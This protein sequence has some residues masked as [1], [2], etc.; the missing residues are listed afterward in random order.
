MT[1][2]AVDAALMGQVRALLARRDA[3]PLP[4]G[5]TRST[6]KLS[7]QADGGGPELLIYDEISYWGVCATDVAAALATVSGDLTV[8]INSPGG[9]V[10]D[11]V[12]IYNLLADYPGQVHVVVDGLAASAA[13]FIA[14]AGDTVTMNRASQMM[15]HDGS[16][17]CWG[18]EADMKA[19]AALLGMVSGTI[20]GIYAARAGGTPEEWRA[21]MLADSGLGT[22][23][24]AEAAVEA[25]L[26]DEL[27]PLATRDSDPE[28]EPAAHASADAL[29]PYGTNDAA[30]RW[31]LAA[32][33][34]ATDGS[35]GPYAGER[36][37][38][39]IM[40]FNVPEGADEDLAR[41]I[42]AESRKRE[43][44]YPSPGEPT[45]VA[46]AVAPESAPT[47]ELAAAEDS[48]PQTPEPELDEW[49]RLIEHLT[50]EPS[51]E[52][53]LASLREA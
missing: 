20:A 6:P 39:I 17:M 14:M 44:Y 45:P 22:W 15:I 19:F 10:F 3:R 38:E 30:G 48:T 51:A 16:G 5:H 52:D 28:P 36:G 23:Y 7:A 21:A 50:A 1:R 2:F 13:S 24:T 40:T 12:A 47:A 33:V 53:L 42:A 8:R 26:A 32:L 34:P 11:G 43:G 49:D 25:G 31:Q 46:G 18:N 9:D 41:R 27:V 4:A 37:P 35:A 29:F